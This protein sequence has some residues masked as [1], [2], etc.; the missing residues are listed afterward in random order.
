MTAE[1]AKQEIEQL[2]KEIERHNYNY[3][4]LA[5]PE[6]DDREYDQLFKR[7]RDLEAQYPQFRTADSPTKR[8]GS[9]VI[10]AFKRVEHSVPMLS[11][12]NTY[13]AKDI[14]DFADRINRNIRDKAIRYCTE[15][16]I[17][18]V[19]FAARYEDGRFTRAISRGNGRVGEDITEHMKQVQGFPLELKEE[20]DVEIRGEVYIPKQVFLEINSVREE[21][22]FEAFA[23]PRNAAAG[24]LRQ[25]DTSYV[26]KRGLKAFAYHLIAPRSFGLQTQTQTLDW[27]EELGFQVEPHRKTFERIDSVVDFW[28]EWTGKRHS[29]A[30][31]IDG[32]VVKVDDYSKH[33]KLGSTSH[34]PRWAIAFKFPA[35]QKET[36]LESITWS[37]GRTGVITPVAH[38]NAVQLAG[39]SVKNAN[40]HNYDNVRDKDIRVGDQI[41]VEKAGDIIPQVVKSVREKRTGDEESV[42]PPDKCPVCSG[43]VG[44]LKEDEVAIRCLNPLC[45][46]KIKRSLEIFASRQAMNIEGLGEKLISNLV[47]RDMVNDVADLYGL[48]EE[49]LIALPRMGQKSANNLMSELKESKEQPLHALLTGLGIPQ[50]GKK[51]ARE[52]ARSFGTIDAIMNAGVSEL[53][54]VDGIGIE[55]ARGIKRFFDTPQ[56]REIIRKLKNYGVNTSG[57]QSEVGKTPLSGLKFVLTGSL[58]DYSRSEMKALIEKNGGEVTGSVSSKTDYLLCGENPGSKLQKARDKGVK[59]I[60]QEDF[61]NLLNQSVS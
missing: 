42:E 19:S 12:E 25:L 50:V 2:K 4:V 39:T 36:R 1:K 49:A 58:P 41:V 61:L 27:L 26:R 10:D 55:M 21:N 46:A 54:E 29:L 16:K 33:E 11:L 34:S 5:R 48:K 51:T 59:V 47:E 13:N 57:E 23:N 44:R 7:L 17:D 15:L 20:Y 38:F 35:E 37:V 45:P 18:G 56:V 14:Y 52:M 24:T 6:I 28:K 53:S 43:D 30:F 3:Y 40:L 8:V 22:G 9:K 31:E 32:L 60:N